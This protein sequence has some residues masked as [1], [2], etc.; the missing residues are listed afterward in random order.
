MLNYVAVKRCY[1]CKEVKWLGDFAGNKTKPRGVASG[2]KDCARA[3]AVA[4]RKANPE[5]VAEGQ[6]R[7]KELNLE[8][9]RAL[10]KAGQARHRARYPDK[11]HT[12]KEVRRRSWLKKKFGI[13]LLDFEWLWDHQKGLCAV[14]DAR[15]EERS[16]G[17]ALDHDHATGKVRGLL[18]NPCNLTEGLIKRI[19]KNPQDF[20][21]RLSRYLNSPPGGVLELV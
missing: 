14:C 17:F 7:W 1:A 19:G 5:K 3:A 18:C 9:Y 8:R 6:L 16:G 21:D 12:S 11:P 13:T 2:C 15:L 4:W 20:A 10:R